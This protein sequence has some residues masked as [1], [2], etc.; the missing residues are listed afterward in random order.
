MRPK[1]VRWAGKW[2]DRESEHIL[3][4][5]RL[6]MLFRTRAEARVWIEQRYGY[7]RTRKDLRAAPHFWRIPTAIKVRIEEV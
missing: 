1:V 2:R 7:I 6:P 5:N 3:F 4:E